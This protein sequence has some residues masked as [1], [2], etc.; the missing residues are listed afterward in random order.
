MS[1]NCNV[2]FVDDEPAILNALKRCARKEAWDIEFA[3]DA[4]LALEIVGEKNPA[5]I[6]TDMRMPGMDGAELLSQITEQHPQIK[7]I[8]LT[9]Y[10]DMEATV[11]AINN[12]RVSRYLSKPWDND[13]LKAAINEAL[14]EYQIREEYAQLVAL[15]EQQN[16]DLKSLNEELEQKVAERTQALHDSMQALEVAHNK[17]KS[18]YASFVRVFAQFIQLRDARISPNIEKLSLRVRLAGEFLGLD[19]ETRDQLGYAAMLRNLGKLTLT[20]EILCLPVEK[21][22]VEQKKAYRRH[23]AVGQTLLLSIDNLQQ[24]ANI[25]GQHQE[26]INGR[27]YPQSLGA[28]EI[29][30][31]AQVLGIVSDYQDLLGGVLTVQRRSSSQICDYLHSQ[32]GVRYHSNVVDAFFHALEMSVDDEQP[33]AEIFVKSSQLRPGMVLSRDLFTPEG[34]FLLAR[35]TELADKVIGKI[36]SF[37]KVERKKFDIFVYDVQQDA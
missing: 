5:V 27:G 11:R 35:G 16:E 4:Q 20:D 19:E 15:T 26:R 28:D 34:L 30:L 1:Q 23:P 33:E 14:Y 6:V 21:M 22:N 36:S 12:G 9:G 37:E 13:Q 8:L 18:S 25:I 32:R 7:Q 10:S 29:S 24:A 2:L 17:L 31:A 3:S